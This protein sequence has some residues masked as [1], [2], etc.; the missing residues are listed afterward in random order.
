M[1]MQRW[2]KRLLA[3]WLKQ[4]QQIPLLEQENGRRYTLLPIV[5]PDVWAFY[6]E[7][8]NSYWVPQEIDMSRDRAE[9]SS[10]SM[11]ELHLIKRVLCFFAAA[12]FMVAEN[13]TNFMQLVKMP[14]AVIFY[15]F[16]V[17]MENIHSETY[18]RL[19]ETFAVDHAEQRAITNAVFTQPAVVAKTKWVENWMDDTK[20]F[21]RRLLAFAIIEGVFFSGSFCAIFWLKSKG[22]LLEG[23]CK[24]NEFIARDE[25]I[26]TRFAVHMYNKHVPADAKPSNEQV[27]HLT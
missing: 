20:P 9:M 27:I 3:R 13:M 11:A 17:A 4:P 24:S 21:S 19:I 22:K 12:D 18:A 23:L 7:H 26:H 6:E 16:Q 15:G 10:L 8:R 2:I 1:A 14:E 5:H 25:G